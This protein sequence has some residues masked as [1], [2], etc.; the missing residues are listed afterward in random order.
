SGNLA[1]AVTRTNVYPAA[2][3]G[4]SDQVESSGRKSLATCAFANSVVM[5]V[6]PPEAVKVVVP[7]FHW[8][9]VLFVTAFLA[10]VK[11]MPSSFK[12]AARDAVSVNDC[13][14]FLAI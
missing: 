12:H 1:V 13:V 4:V 8:F 5:V 6:S 11:L 7:R 10:P 9:L 2:F 3:G 14:S